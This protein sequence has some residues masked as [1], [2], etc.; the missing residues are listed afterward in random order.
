M[1]HTL[2]FVL[3]LFGTI[4]GSFLNVC[5]YRIPRNESV[6]T[7]GSH[8]PHCQSPIKPYDNIPILSY[9]IL[10]GKCRH[11]QD[12]ISIRYPLVELLTGIIFALNHTV[13]GLTISLGLNLILSA[14]LIII[15][16]I[17][18]DTMI[19]NNRFHIIIAA[20]GII[21]LL[22]RYQSLID[23]IGGIFIVSIPLGLIA[24]FTGG[25]GGGDVKLMASAGLYL[26]TTNILVA[27]FIGVLSGGLYA[28][29][30]LIFKNKQR[31]AEMPFG[32]FLCLGI[33]IASLYGDQLLQL[34]LGLI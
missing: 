22:L 12:K 9:I 25:I 21:T 13:F 30:L 17:D 1:T 24:Y 3:F 16:F 20:L 5:I 33:F 27:F 18:F 11:C 2:T 19:I 32:P 7:D 34:Y 8:C 4:I 28:I 29:Y 6:I 10:K 15:T 14:C 23:A 31:Q 26:G